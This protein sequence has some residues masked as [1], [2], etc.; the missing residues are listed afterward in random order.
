[1]CE[2]HNAGCLPIRFNTGGLPIVRCDDPT[3]A[4]QPL[5]ERARRG[6]AVAQLWQ[7]PQGF[8]VP[9]SYRKFANLAPSATPLPPVAGRCGCVDPGADWCRRGPGSST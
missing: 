4:E 6:E 3:L 2:P 9:G 7:A 8:V 1:M 5:F